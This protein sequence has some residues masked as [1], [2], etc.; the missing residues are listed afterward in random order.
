MQTTVLPPDSLEAIKISSVVREVAT[1]VI[2]ID[3]PLDSAVD[4]KPEQISCDDP[5]ISVNPSS[6]TIPPKSVS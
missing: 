1:Y 3:N 2:S 4:F 6:F 5:N